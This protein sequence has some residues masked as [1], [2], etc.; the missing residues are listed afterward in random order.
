MAND[1]NDKVQLEYTQKIVEKERQIDD[2][3]REKRQTQEIIGS[4]ESELTRNFRQVQELN[5][6]AIKQGSSSARWEQAE[7]AGKKKHFG[8][9]FKEQQQELNE[10]YT[11]TAEKFNEERSE[12]QKE[13]NEV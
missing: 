12:L 10:T 8:Q 4:L 1:P 11:K 3:N 9:F 6:E 13:R 2:L 5:D 7:L